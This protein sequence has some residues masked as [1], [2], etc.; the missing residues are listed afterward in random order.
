MTSICIQGFHTL[1]IY[2]SYR[3]THTI[4]C[5]QPHARTHVC[6]TQYRAR[7]VKQML[8]LPILCACTVYKQV[9]IYRYDLQSTRC[10]K[11]NTCSGSGVSPSPQDPANSDSFLFVCFSE[12]YFQFGFLQATAPQSQHQ[13]C[14]RSQAAHVPKS[15]VVSERV[16]E[17]LKPAETFLRGR[18][19]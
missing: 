19:T 4:S 7:T 13:V 9:Y 18:A 11:T 8:P 2:E 5:T 6:T 16:H 17:L 10:V 1:Y 14:H 15:T 12:L 3:Y